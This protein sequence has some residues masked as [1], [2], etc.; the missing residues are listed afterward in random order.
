MNLKKLILSVLFTITL[1]LNSTIA[2][3]AVPLDI[4]D[5]SEY[6]KEAIT[7]L[8]NQNI[9]TGDNLGNYNPKEYITRG[10]AVTLIVK[11]LNLDTSVLPDKPTFK[12]VPTNHWAYKYVETAYKEGI[13]KGISQDKFGINNLCTREQVT[14][15]F[16]KSLGLRSENIEGEENLS[17]I[18]NFSDKDS[19]SH[20]AKG[21][22]EFCVYTRLL[23]GVSKTKFD[24]KGYTTKE[25][26]SVIINRF[27]KDFKDL[28]ETAYYYEVATTPNISYISDSNCFYVS[29]SEDFSYASISKLYNSNGDQL[30]AIMR[31]PTSTYKP[32]TRNNKIF[33]KRY[34]NIQE[35]GTYTVKTVYRLKNN[36][37][38]RRFIYNT[39][40]M[41][42]PNERSILAIT[43]KTTAEIAIYFPTSYLDKQSVENINNYTLLDELGNE[44]KI[45]QVNYEFLSN[46]SVLILEK[47]IENK[48]KLSIKINNIQMTKNNDFETQ[49]VI[50]PTYSATILMGDKS[51]FIKDLEFNKHNNDITE[52]QTHLDNLKNKDIKVMLNGDIIPFKS[53]PIVENDEILVPLELLT[54]TYVDCFY[55]PRTELIHITQT[56]PAAMETHQNTLLKLNKDF[57]FLNSK[58]SSS[59]D[60][61]EAAKEYLVPLKA[62]PRKIDNVVYFP[63]GY[64][65]EVLN[66]PLSIDDINGIIH[67]KSDSPDYP[68]LYETLRNDFYHTRKGQFSLNTEFNDIDATT[69]KNVGRESIT[70]NGILND[71]DVHFNSQHKKISKDNNFDFSREIMNIDNSGYEKNLETGEFKEIKGESRKE[72]DLLLNTNI[73]HLETDYRFGTKLTEGLF[74]NYEAIPFKRIGSVKINDVDTVKYTVDVNSNNFKSIDESFYLLLKNYRFSDDTFNLLNFYI[75]SKYTV[76]IY[77][78]DKNQLVKEVIKT[79]YYSIADNLYK[80]FIFEISLYNIDNPPEIKK[81]LLN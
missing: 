45:K 63:L 37:Y 44:V 28:K 38:G 40:Q 47:P 6:A 42:L 56:S 62:A 54:H 23:Q 22:V 34:E 21:Y 68:M 70:M 64:V 29:F 78:N 16:T 18:N 46:H 71:Y 69:G 10:E 49:L 17:S 11:T 75:P 9:I 52:E 60:N 57:A 19:I 8:Y 72:L 58:V 31:G 39:E 74:L 2:N 4:N 25:Q 33:A 48:T 5:S 27:I 80:N 12:D 76:E 59:F 26:V 1:F 41:T 43:P 3:A 67:V 73:L 65:S 32:I 77:I 13:T 24:P 14:V 50:I 15:M 35:G 20:W 51:K 79:N 7:F 55:N 61:V 81:P 53:A 66:Y 36:K 30:S